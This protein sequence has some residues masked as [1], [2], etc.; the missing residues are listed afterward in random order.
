MFSVNAT[1]ALL[2]SLSQVSN[3]PQE[4][5]A[6]FGNITPNKYTEGFKRNICLMLIKTLICD[7]ENGSIQ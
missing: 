4:N 7:I 2:L 5:S 6:A 1:I 3:Y